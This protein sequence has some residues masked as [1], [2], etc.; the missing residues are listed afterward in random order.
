M[1]LPNYLASRADWNHEIETRL[2]A[3]YLLEP[4]KLP[5]AWERYYP[6]SLAETVKELQARGFGVTEDTIDA[7]CDLASLRVI[8][9]SYVFYAEDID[10][11]ANRMA[12]VNCITGL[13]AH[14]K[15]YGISFRDEADAIRSIQRRKVVDAA[16]EVGVSEQEMWAG[17]RHGI[18]HAP[19]HEKW[20]PAE[21][22][23]WFADNRANPAFLH[24]LRCQQE[25]K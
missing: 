3:Q 16:A 22:R 5:V 19:G 13:A 4:D 15:A 21:A 10:R 18:F 1:A 6:L 24:D 7:F 17:I 23:Q 25:V 11:I 14:R 8:G 2:R 9:R 12:E 20:D